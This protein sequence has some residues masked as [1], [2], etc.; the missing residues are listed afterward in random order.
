MADLSGFDAWLQQNQ[1]TSG[2]GGYSS[3]DEMAAS[4]KTHTEIIGQGQGFD[5]RDPLVTHS[6]AELQSTYSKEMQ[7]NAINKATEAT[8]TVA[9]PGQDVFSKKLAGMATG[10]FS[11]DDPSYQWRLQQGQQAVERSAAA[12]GQLGS[13]NVLTAL[14]DYAQGAASTEYGA[15]FARMLQG[16]ENATNQYSTAYSTLASMMGQQTSQGQ[17]GVSQG[18][19]GLASSSQRFNQEVKTN[20]SKGASGV[21]STLYS[22]PTG[23]SYWAQQDAQDAQSAQNS[24]Y[25]LNGYQPQQSTYQVPSSGSGSWSNDSTGTGGSW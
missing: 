20:Q 18:Q 15:Q 25:T 7:Q 21:L 22:S 10:Q 11:T 6:R 8:S 12:K 5:Y 1:Y 24:S 4:R 2:A 17:L 9:T 23:S 19:L 13:G 3:A 16:S 14:T